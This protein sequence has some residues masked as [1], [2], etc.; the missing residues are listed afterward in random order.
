MSILLVIKKSADRT[1]YQV[2]VSTTPAFQ[3]YWLPV[4]RELNLILVPQL[5]ENL[6]LLEE[7]RRDLVAEFRRLAQWFEMHSRTIPSEPGPIEARIRLI[8]S[9]L[10][11][12][13]CLDYEITFC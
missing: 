9:E 1:E 3:Q 11:Q 2:P 13:D 6:F 7:D 5:Q 4:A 12:H 8:L 10:E